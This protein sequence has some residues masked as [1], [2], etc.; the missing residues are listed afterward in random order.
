MS[1]PV[2]PSIDAASGEN[3]VMPPSPP[4]DEIRT[5]TSST[6][7]PTVFADAVW[8][9]TNLGDVIRLQFIE[10]HLEPTNSIAPGIKAR[11]V[12]TLVMPR[13]GFKNM[14]RY[15]QER[16]ELFDRLDAEGAQSNGPASTEDGK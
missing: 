16:D 2:E 15:L 6:D 9:A 13:V 8:F 11:H 4:D 10:N 14:L 12:G 3:I 5:V 7:Y 1:D